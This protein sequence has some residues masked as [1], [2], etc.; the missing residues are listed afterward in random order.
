M[1]LGKPLL[2]AL[3]RMGYG[4]IVLDT[5]GRIRLVNHAATH[6][7]TEN[8]PVKAQLSGSDWREAIKALLRLDATARLTINDDAW[9]VIRRDETGRRPL[10][11]H[12][13]P[14]ASDVPLGPGTVLI[15]VDLEVTPRLAPETLQ[16]I[17]GL[18][19]AEA[20]LA[21]EIASGCSLDTIAAGHHV[22]VA[23]ARKQLA[24][25]FVKTYTHR[26]AD[27]V[28]LLARIAILP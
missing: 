19:P 20:K 2:D 27:L 17:F 4:G 24:S 22:T 15:L 6:L 21:I 25:V 10:V 12:T 16:K 14:I 7:L 11:L 23:T 26:Q 1:P 8:S 9:V 28:A 3:D 13:V 5:S 18:T